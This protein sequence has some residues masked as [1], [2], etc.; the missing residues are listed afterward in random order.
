MYY[1]N[2]NSPVTRYFSDIRYSDNII[3]KLAQSHNSAPDIEARIGAYEKAFSNLEEMNGGSLETRSF[4][5]TSGL[6]NLKGL[7]P[8]QFIDVTVAAMIKSIAGFVTIERGLDAPRAYMP[9]MNLVSASEPSDREVAGFQYGT[10]NNVPGKQGEF[11]KVSP[12]IG[13]DAQY[14]KATG[15]WK[16]VLRSAQHTHR[17]DVAT[18]QKGIEYLDTTSNGSFVPGSLRI[19]VLRSQNSQLESFTITDD[20]KGNILAP[21]GTGVTKGSINYRNGL[22]KLDLDDANKLV[23]GDAYS[24]NVAYDTPRTPINKLKGDLDYYE[25]TTYPQSILAETNMIT[26]LVAQK[27]MQIDMKSILKKRV[28]DE[29]VK[30]INKTIIDELVNGYTGNTE[31]MDLSGFSIKTNGY[32][33]YLRLFTHGL[34]QINSLLTMKSWKSVNTSAY[35]V[36]IKVAETF[37]ACADIGTFVPNNEYGY[38]EDLIGY[39]NGIP[40]VQSYRLKGNEGYAIHKTSDGLMAPLA[41]GIF[42]PINDL[43]EVG[44]FQNPTQS[45]SGIFSYEGVKFLTS[46][47][48]QRFEV[49]L[50]IGIDTVASA[51]LAMDNGVYSELWASH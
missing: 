46:D 40:V 49:K 20:G 42:L 1:M 6:H 11:T 13:P 26:N 10:Q 37:R 15:E 44:N 27:S 12:N 3:N 2:Y 25:M 28:M 32:D 30:L 29:Y 47:L 34:N 35:L 39:Y 24:I 41:R 45:A 23:K 43:P 21:A 22:I 4:N 17:F 51:K 31:V 16:T 38:I 8:T 36:G 9:F 7:S 48:V 19:E 50:P 5:G 14:D 18:D 33:S